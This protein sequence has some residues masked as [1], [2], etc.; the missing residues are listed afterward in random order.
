MLGMTTTE[1]SLTTGTKEVAEALGVG[2][3]EG[4]LVF[5]EGEARGGKSVLSQHIAHGVL[6]SKACSVVYYTTECGVEDLMANM[7]SISLDV[8]K[9]F[10]T[11]RFRVYIA[12]SNNVFENTRETL[13]LLVKHISELPERFKLVIVDSIT[14]LMTRINLTAKIDFLQTCKELCTKDRSII[15]VV[16]THLFEV[17]TLSRAY[18][19]SDYYLKLRSKD[20]MLESGQEDTRVIK[21]LEV[22]KLG[23]AERHA[24]EGIKFEIKPEVGI[25]FLPFVKVKV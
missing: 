4:S 16:D 19:M 20:M 22:T 7:D 25:Q 6:C 24:S 9:D 15:L 1:N 5:I 12:G 2:I 21:I 18:A 14:P 10:V 3:H 11:D 17:K 8:R 13:Q 23:G